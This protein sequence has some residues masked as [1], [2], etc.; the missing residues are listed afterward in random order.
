LTKEALN[1][2]WSETGGKKAPQPID[3]IDILQPQAEAGPRVGHELYTKAE[4]TTNDDLIS[5]VGVF[6]ASL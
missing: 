2:V 3:Y 5:Y 1:K 4:V 6:S